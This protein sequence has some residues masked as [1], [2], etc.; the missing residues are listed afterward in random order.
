MIAA[1]RDEGCLA[2]E[3][4]I[5]SPLHLVILIPVRDD[6][7]SVSELLR[8]LDQ[9]LLQHHCIV[10]VLLVDDGSIE[11][12]NAADYLRPFA[13]LR[14][15]RILRLR[16]N[17]GHQRAIAVGLVHIKKFIPSDAV[18]VMDGDGED[19]PDGALQLLYA[20][21]GAAA[22]FAKR[23][24]RTESFVFKLFY[25]LYK[26]I[27]RGLTGVSVEV[28]NFSL[29]PSNDVGT[30][31]VMSELWNHY[32]AAV[33]R[34]G[35]PVKKVPIP[36]GQRIAGK[37]KMNFVTLAAHGMSAISVFGDIIGVRLLV[38]SVLGAF[39]AVLG[40][41]AVFLV[42]IFTHWAI[43]GWAIDSIG[44]LAVILIQC[45]TMAFCLTFTLLS[46]RVDFGFIP[47]RD[48]ELF[49]DGVQ[50]IYRND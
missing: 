2:A 5:V 19:T 3:P 42:Q 49:V 36:R 35:L 16:R 29:I 27:H 33:I 12:A 47:L 31:V 14:R 1:N 37:S 13:T 44:T 32:A 50:E 21:T 25:R 7:P 34:S 41:F 30:L 8:R 9:T 46:N 22:I 6:W 4:G 10:D 23:S 43:P 45:I 26:I 17:L 39:L 40:I 28:G 24:R 18:L 20:F 15:I 48:S 11:N 38:A